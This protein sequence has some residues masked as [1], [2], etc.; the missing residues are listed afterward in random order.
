VLLCANRAQIPKIN[1]KCRWRLNTLCDFVF[2]FPWHCARALN[3][4]RT[5]SRLDGAT[6]RGISNGASVFV[7]LRLIHAVVRKRI[8]LRADSAEHYAVGVHLVSGQRT[9]IVTLIWRT[10][11]LV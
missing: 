3:R 8:H 2:V 7:E 6:I 10:L 9:N 1:D 5:A 4:A 11:Q